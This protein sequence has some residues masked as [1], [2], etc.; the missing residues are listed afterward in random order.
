MTKTAVIR[1]TRCTL[2]EMAAAETAARRLADG[3]V[4]LTFTMDA[5]LFRNWL[6]LLEHY[7]GCI[8]PPRNH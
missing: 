3:G 4:E 7:A 2:L 5:D 6:E 8:L 1:D